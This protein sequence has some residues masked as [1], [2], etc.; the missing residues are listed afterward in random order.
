VIDP[1]MEFAEGIKKLERRIA[2][3]ERTVGAITTLALDSLTIGGDPVRAV[4]AW[5]TLT[6]SIASQTIIRTPQWRY[7]GGRIELR[8]EFTRTASM[9]PGTTIAALG[10]GGNPPTPSEDLAAMAVA[11][12]AAATPDAQMLE[13]QIDSGGLGIRTTGGTWTVAIG[14]TVKLDPVWWPNV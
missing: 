14:D 9:A 13:I 7:N 11:L 1:G 2:E 10:S 5:Q 4:G 8:G 3:L 12:I 6:L